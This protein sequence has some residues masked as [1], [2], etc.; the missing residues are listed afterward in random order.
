MRKKRVLVFPGGTEIGLEIWKSLRYC[1]EISLFS[2]G[3]HVSNHAPYV[4]QE[5]F[6][7][8]DVHQPNW[9]ETLS[10]IIQKHNIDYV[11]PAHDDV[12]L[13]LAQNANKFC[14]QIVSSPLSTCI[15]CRSKVRTYEKFKKLLPVP[16]IFNKVSE[17]D[18]FPV[19]VKPDVGQG[20]QYASKVD[21]LETLQVVL[22]NNPDLII[23]EYL[24]GK[25]YTV[26]CFTDR[27]KGLLFCGGRERI[28]I[29]A[30]ISMN[31]KPVDAKTSMLFRKVAKVISD[32]LDFHGAWFFQLK[33]DSSGSFKLLEIAPRISGT[34]ATYRVL[35]VNFALLSIYENE[36][37]DIMI[38]RNNCNV[39]IDKALE[40]RYKHNLKY[41]KVYVDL[42]DTL[43]IDDKVNPQLIQF[44]YQS[45][46]KGCKLVLI[47]KTTRQGNIQS[48]LKQFRLGGIFDETIFLKK[49]ES[50]FDFINPQGSIFIDDSFTERK[51][52][53]DRLG[54]PTFDCSMIEF[55]IDVRS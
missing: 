31:S 34:M 33:I 13:A 6:M 30:G 7:V 52:V 49:S 3:N 4:F 55:L 20:S 28:R 27:R 18:K 37:A 12:I 45:L 43:I 48:I 14:A 19:F 10:S 21:N 47:T 36:G 15:L 11:F 9:V 5:C 8:P 40:N 46:N 2:A 1:K 23:S 54:I 35:G 25:E 42:D 38:M 53:F 17:V 51:A 50:K 16:K 41:N 39:Q 26:D 44:L 22:R 32:E 29:R 24:P